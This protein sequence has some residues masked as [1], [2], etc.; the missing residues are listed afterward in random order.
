MWLCLYHVD[1]LAARRSGG[2]CIQ[3]SSVV[4]TNAE[5]LSTRLNA[6]AGLALH[7]PPRLTQECEVWNDRF[8]R[9]VLS[10]HQFFVRV[11]LMGNCPWEAAVLWTDMNTSGRRPGSFP[12]EPGCEIWTEWGTSVPGGGARSFLRPFTALWVQCSDIC[13]AP[14][15]VLP[16]FVWEDKLLWM[17][18][19]LVQFCL[20]IFYKK[21]R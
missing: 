8:S 4:L 7:T 13:V 14:A 17:L 19:C 2:V 11:S 12:T 6:V 1:N 3:G 5:E 10:F 15:W 21:K 18:F 16:G 20:L 9:V